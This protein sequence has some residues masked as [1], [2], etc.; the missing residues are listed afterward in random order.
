[1]KIINI[2]AGFQNAY[3]EPG[4]QLWD[5]PNLI[6]AYHTRGAARAAKAA[7]QAAA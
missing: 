5:G 7:R 4:W 3:N 1:M 2:L 6:G